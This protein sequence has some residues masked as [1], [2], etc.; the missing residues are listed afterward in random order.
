MLAI[1]NQLVV[2]VQHDANQGLPLRVVV[3]AGTPTEAYQM[4]NTKSLSR[5]WLRVK[6]DSGIGLPMVNVLE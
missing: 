6:V 1:T 2:S 3:S 5:L 4:P